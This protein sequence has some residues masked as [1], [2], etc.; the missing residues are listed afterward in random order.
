MR[1]KTF[2]ATLG[3]KEKRSARLETVLQEHAEKRSGLKSKR[4]HVGGLLNELES[5]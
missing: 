1:S 5:G 3:E 2:D 4:P